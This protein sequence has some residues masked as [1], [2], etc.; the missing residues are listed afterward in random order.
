MLLRDLRELRQQLFCASHLSLLQCDAETWGSL[1]GQLPRVGSG[2]RVMKKHHTRGLGNRL[3]EQFEALRAELG[4]QTCNACQ[5][6]AG[7]P[8]SSEPDD[9]LEWIA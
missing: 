9:V 3:V 7:A 4:C 6:S 8:G 5:I 1:L 2:Q